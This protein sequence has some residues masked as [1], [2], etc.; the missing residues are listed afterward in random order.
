MTCSKIDQQ[1]ENI[2]LHVRPV[3]YEAKIRLLQLLHES[4]D[5]YII[6]FYYFMF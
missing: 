5:F 2:Q 3:Y 4:V 6:Y 1:L